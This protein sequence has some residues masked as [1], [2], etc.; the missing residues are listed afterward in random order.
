M[1]PAKHP[2]ALAGGFCR[3]WPLAIVMLAVVVVNSG[4]FAMAEQK[5]CSH[6]LDNSHTIIT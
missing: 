5:D 4:A 6:F 3:Q 2:L 1:M